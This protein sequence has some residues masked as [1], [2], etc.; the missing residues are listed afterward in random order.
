M[1]SRF[2]ACLKATL[3]FEGGLSD[4][5]TDR[6][7]R[8][9]LGITQGTLNRARRMGIVHVETVDELTR[10]DAATI[11]AAFYWDRCRCGQ[12]SDGLD[13][14]VFDCAVNCGNGTAGRCLQRALGDMGHP[15]VVDG[16]I[17]AQTCGAAGNACAEGK[18][19]ALIEACLLRREEYYR[20][21][22]EAHPEQQ[23]FARGWQ[24]RVNRLR[25][26]VA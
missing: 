6:G 13:L 14:V 18:K 25:G 22:I 7:G 3:G 23:R 9:N 24:N 21:V 12:L 11:Y 2:E 17:G 16:A 20:A 15:V 4:D 19:A 5:P 8:T 26:M 10:H 1:K